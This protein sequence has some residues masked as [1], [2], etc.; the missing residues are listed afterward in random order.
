M[1]VPAL[2]KKWD[3][4]TIASSTAI[5]NTGI[6]V[7][8]KTW[9]SVTR[10]RSGVDTVLSVD[11]EYIVGSLGASGGCVLEMVEQAASDIITTVLP[12]QVG[13]FL[14]TQQARQLT[15]LRLRQTS[16]SWS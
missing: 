2:A 16:T 4:V 6:Y 5:V 3:Q 14:D 7:T 15:R 13:S 1:T 11:T 8:D 12:S 10:T 9:L